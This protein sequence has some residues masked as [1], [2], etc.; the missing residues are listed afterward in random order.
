M[1]GKRLEMQTSSGN[2]GRDQRCHRWN[3]HRNIEKLLAS[4][5]EKDDPAPNPNNPKLG[6]LGFGAFFCPK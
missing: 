6:L 1:G 5:V 4:R 2:F 3:I